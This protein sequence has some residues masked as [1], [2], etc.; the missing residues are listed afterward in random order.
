MAAG[1]KDLTS[2]FVLRAGGPSIEVEIG[3]NL[4][5]MD[6]DIFYNSTVRKNHKN[7]NVNLLEELGETPY[8]L[9]RIYKLE[10]KTFFDIS[11][12]KGVKEGIPWDYFTV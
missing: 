12:K 3:S 2:T 11:G 7:M 10:G 9:L 6:P 1:K 4:C 5:L 8:K